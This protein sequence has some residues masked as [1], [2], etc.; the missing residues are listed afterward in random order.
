[1]WALSSAQLAEQDTDH[2]PE[3]CFTVTVSGSMGNEWVDDSRTVGEKRQTRHHRLLWREGKGD[4]KF[5]SALVTYVRRHYQ[6]CGLSELGRQ[7]SSDFHSRD[8][9]AT[10]ALRVTS[11]FFWGGGDAVAA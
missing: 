4:I 7:I 5:S 2:G 1:M 3:R 8:T 9:G 10:V 11:L 6:K